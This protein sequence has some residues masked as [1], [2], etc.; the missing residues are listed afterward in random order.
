[1]SVHNRGSGKWEAGSAGQ[2]ELRRLALLFT[3]VAMAACASQ[4]VP[5]TTPAPAPADSSLPASRLPLPAQF[6]RSQRP[7]LG[8]APAVSLPPIQ[9]RQLSNGL[10]I[11]IPPFIETGTKIVVNT[12]EVSYVERAK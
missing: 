10:K 9:T 4:P 3:A 6:D 2:G 11:M 5:A 7:A 8:P 12:E 1:M